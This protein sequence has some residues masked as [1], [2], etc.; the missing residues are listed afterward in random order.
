MI[1]DMRSVLGA[2]ALVMGSALS[3]AASAQ[4]AMQLDLMFRDTLL[5]RPAAHE[6]VNGSRLQREHREIATR[7]PRRQQRHDAAPTTR[8]ANDR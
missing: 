8:A 1:F 6:P 2:G 4:D 3:S 5:R 7:H